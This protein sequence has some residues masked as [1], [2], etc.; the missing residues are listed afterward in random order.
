MVQYPWGSPQ[1]LLWRRKRIRTTTSL[2]ADHKLI[3]TRVD[4]P[5]QEESE[6]PSLGAWLN[7]HHLQPRTF[8]PGSEARLEGRSEEAAENVVKC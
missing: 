1:M 6:D 7:R 4:W 8:W 5:W 2:S 3:E